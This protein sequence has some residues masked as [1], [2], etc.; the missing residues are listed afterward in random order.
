MN[1]RKKINILFFLQL[2]VAIFL[3]ANTAFAEEKI[4]NFDTII[5][6]EKSGIINV[7]EKITYDFGTEERHGIF[8]DI[9]TGGIY[10]IEHAPRG[11]IGI[12]VLSVTNEN[13]QEYRYTVSYDGD[14]QNIKIGN[15]DINITGVHTYI[16]NYVAK[17]TLGYFTDYDEVYWNATGNEWKIPIEHSTATVILPDSTVP[18][19]DKVKCFTGFKGETRTC[20][21]ITGEDS[22]VITFTQDT[23]QAGQGLTIAVGFKKGLVPGYFFVP[24]WY[25]HSINYYLIALGVFILGL[26]FLLNKIFFIYLPEIHKR[27]KSIITEFEPPLGMTPSEVGFIYN[28]NYGQRYR[29]L[30]GDVLYLATQGYITIE[31][32]ITKKNFLKVIM[33]LRGTIFFFV[34]VGV[35]SFFADEYIIILFFGGF[36]FLAFLLDL[37]FSKNY[38]KNMLSS[39]SSSFTRT[40]KDI[41][42]AKTHLDTLY[43][44]ITKEGESKTTE[45]LIK[46]EP[47]YLFEDYFNKAESSVIKDLS[48]VDI[49]K[50]FTFSS[51]INA[52]FEAFE[53]ILKLFVGFILFSILILVIMLVSQVVSR[54]TGVGLIT[55]FS[56]IFVI[57]GIFILFRIA[58]HI[59]KKNLSK[60]SDEYYSVAGLYKYIDIAEKARLMAEYSSTDLPKIFSKL[61]PF[62]VALGL[63]DKWVTVFGGILTTNPDWY[64]STDNNFSSGAFT[65]SVSSLSSSMSGASVSGTPSSSGGSG[66]GGSSGG[67]GGGGGGG[68]W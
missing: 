18:S 67:G 64:R 24:K 23:L 55:I 26:L 33:S 19:I 52:M 2:F 28:R 16:I 9:P 8:R 17:N 34:A 61:L 60:M 43:Q 4:T 32:T 5:T 7:T 35:V 50:K 22:N 45:Q 25:N 51:F 6:V 49:N 56:P 29:S 11:N 53:S 47:Y 39:I 58:K 42:G 65:S 10:T 59:Y 36:F 21:N 46:E 66:G 31:N 38:I 40:S 30:A 48:Y 15:P 13:G 37:I 44:I 62:A 12:D 3:F 63:G 1:F 57:L 27:K 14:I 41:H 20:T 54:N 68:S